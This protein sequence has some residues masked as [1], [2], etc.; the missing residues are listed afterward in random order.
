MTALIL[1][2]V[3]ASAKSSF[4]EVT[5][6]VESSARDVVALDRLLASLRPRNERDPRR[7]QRTL[8]RAGSTWSGR[9]ARPGP[10]NSIRRG[11]RRMPRDWR[12]QIRRSRR[13]AMTRN[14][15]FRPARGEVAEE[16]LEARWLASADSGASVSGL[17]L[18]ILHVLAD[19][20]VRQLRV[21]LLHEIQRSSRSSSVCAA[22]VWQRPVSRSLEMDEPF[23]GLL[24]VSADPL[25][26]RARTSTN[27]GPPSF[28]RSRRVPDG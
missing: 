7:L 24:K 3:T 5:V 15:G 6:A 16:M 17:F 9:R 25:L 21:G 1:G 20:H 27:S 23:G 26:F 13:R 18:V 14:G 19:D 8:L 22:S 11:S 10:R 2:L 28:I 12:E 4:D